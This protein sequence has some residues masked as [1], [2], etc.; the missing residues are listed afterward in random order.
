MR[1]STRIVKR[2][3]ALFLVVLMSINSFG[4]VVSDNDG[5]AFITKAEFDSLKNNFQA[6]IDQYNTSIDSKIDGAIASYLAGINVAKK[7][8]KKIVLSDFK[9]ITMMNYALSN[10]WKIP[11]FNLAVSMNGSTATV[12]SGA[13]PATW[14]AQAQINYNRA[15]NQYCKRLNVDAGIETNSMPTYV[16]WIG[17]A[18]NQ[19]D[20]IKCSRM[21]YTSGLIQSDLGH[22]GGSTTA[23]FRFTNITK[24][25]AGYFPTLDT[26][27][28]NVWQPRFFWHGRDDDTSADG[29]KSPSTILNK[30]N[31]LSIE[32]KTVNN[33]IYE[34]E[35]I[36]NWNNYTFPQLTDTDWINTL[37]YIENATITRKQALDQATKNSFWTGHTNSAKSLDARRVGECTYAQTTPRAFN[38]YYSGDNG[39]NDTSAFVG[40]GILNASYN[41]EHIYQSS[42]EFSDNI[43][44]KDLRSGY[45]NL[46]QG[47]PILAAKEEEKVTL[48]LEF[49]NLYRDGV[50]QTIMEQD[51]YLSTIPFGAGATL[52]DETKRIKCDGQPTGQNYMTTTNNKIK[53]NFEMDETSIVYLKWKPHDD[54]GK[55]SCD[56]N[57][58]KNPTY[59]VETT[60]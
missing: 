29:Y 35:H 34:Y 38:G 59:I 46:L 44:S 26:E 30:S 54:S 57:L 52:T 37:R 10:E 22:I 28:T 25:L 49:D 15:S 8:T 32:L 9:N 19:V 3:L 1:K 4:A 23:Y 56:L 21:Q 13:W 7:T 55:W 16:Y 2:L 60:S 12:A 41:S 5:S 39:S 40:V 50:Q 58:T 27:T 43:G 45:L 36:M 51:V 24:I 53:L 11:N 17:R 47:F 42:T 20:S 31:S 33:K 14:W 6:Q 18:L 48:E